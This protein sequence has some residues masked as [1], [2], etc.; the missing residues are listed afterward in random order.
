MRPGQ[1]QT[2]PENPEI[3][4]DLK[5]RIFYELPA[6]N[7]AQ[8]QVIQEYLNTAQT[9][10]RGS[11]ADV[12]VCR[13]SPLGAFC[14]K[15]TVRKTP[16][17][18]YNPGI[19]KEVDRHNEAYALLEEARKNSQTPL[20]HIPKP[21]MTFRSADGGNEWLIMEYIEGKTLWRIIM[22]QLIAAQDFRGLQGWKKEDLLA[23]DDETLSDIIVKIFRLQQ[24]QH[25]LK[26][27]EA[28]LNKI[29]GKKFIKKELFLALANTVRFLN[30]NGFY[31]RDMHPQ[32]IMFSADK[33]WL[34]DFAYSIF[35]PQKTTQNPYEELKL[36][37]NLSF[38]RDE[39]IVMMLKEFVETTDE[40]QTVSENEQ[41]AAT[42][43]EIQ[44]TLQKLAREKRSKILEI[45]ESDKKR[46]ITSEDYVKNIASDPALNTKIMQAISMGSIDNLKKLVRIIGLLEF[47]KF[48]STA[49]TYEFFNQKLQN[50]PRK[51]ILLN[52]IR[53]TLKLIS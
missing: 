33:V 6:E 7:A 45:I 47:K 8:S 16:R 19:I 25:P 32:N 13:H 18:V 51:D 10:A 46:K 48:K 5:I 52:H 31:H 2:S 30:S 41:M 36:G 12:Q 15:K 20:A 17:S 28:L 14:V 49:E 43:R 4:S 21:I 9:V 11:E 24:I 29:R 38:S 35:D 40:E 3:I 42:D 26:Q 22:E 1:K 37:A 34:I 53:S 23:L 27:F 39:G 50:N 44:Q